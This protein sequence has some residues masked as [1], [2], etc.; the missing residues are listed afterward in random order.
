MVY[1]P[2]QSNRLSFTIEIGRNLRGFF[3]R[4]T[5]NSLILSSLGLPSGS[6]KPDTLKS[7]ITPLS[8][9]TQYSLVRRF[10]GNLLRK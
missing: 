5:P 3:M 1:I 2:L 7:R 10:E 9:R 4:V 8:Y 6:R